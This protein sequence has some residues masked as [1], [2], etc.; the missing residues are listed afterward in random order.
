MLVGISYDMR[1][2]TDINELT[3]NFLSGTPVKEASQ[4]KPKESRQEESLAVN[5]P[6]SGQ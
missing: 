5:I 2:S 3:D 6:G 4:L 1:Y